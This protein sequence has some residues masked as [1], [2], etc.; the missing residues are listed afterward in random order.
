GGHLA[1]RLSGDAFPFEHGHQLAA[2]GGAAGVLDRGRQRDIAILLDQGGREILGLFSGQHLV[3]RFRPADRRSAPQSNW[4]A[5]LR[6]PMNSASCGG[7]LRGRRAH[8]SGCRERRKER[9]T[10][11]WARSALC[12]SAVA[13]VS[14]ATAWPHRSRSRATRASTALARKCGKSSRATAIA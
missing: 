13:S 6:I 4:A 1:Q 14:S 10:S 3:P 11:S 5:A 7:K 12:A 9:L 2:R 8:A